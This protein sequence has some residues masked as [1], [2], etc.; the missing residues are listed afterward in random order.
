MLGVE[1]I[2]KA[3]SGIVGYTV[4]FYI[5]VKIV[6]GSFT[7]FETLKRLKYFSKPNLVVGQVRLIIITII[8]YFLQ[9]YLFHLSVSMCPNSN[10]K[11]LFQL[12]ERQPFVI[13]LEEAATQD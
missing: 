7:D 9:M 11:V 5:C 12:T 8:L 6:I 4:S 10:Q 1:V 2:F 13:H 3:I